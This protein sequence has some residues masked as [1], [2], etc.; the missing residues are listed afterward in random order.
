MSEKYTFSVIGGDCR[1]NIIIKELLSK[2]HSV[3]V[4]SMS[5]SSAGITGAEI[6]SSLEKA[7]SE[8]AVLLLPLPATKDGITVNLTSPSE[9][10]RIS[11]ILHLFR[12][13]ES[14][15]LVG[16]IIP[17]EL[18]LAANEAGIEVV[19]F[20]KSEALQEKNALPSAEG[21]IMVAMENTDTII[22]SM[23]V[24][25]CGF[26]RIGKILASK[27]KL[28]GAYVSVAARRDEVLCEIAMS[29]FTPID[30]RNAEQLSAAT[31][32]SAVIFNTV[33]VQ[34]FNRQ[35]IDKINGDPL[36][37]E[38]ASSPGGIDIPLARS[39]GIRII[40][41]PSLPGKYAPATAGKYIF[42]TITDILDQRGMKI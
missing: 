28:L 39:R 12:K 38:I 9:Y 17:P 19:D 11:D 31:N 4:F 34:I 42:E 33:P 24:L 22:E 21:A 13:N 18:V 36:Y 27:L 7:V 15:V 29:G 16:G 26:G 25:V 14:P 35:I 1:Q 20:Y 40:F 37:I 3:K 6:S 8:T 5:S 2:G 10:V 32:R 41:A 30:L 23:S